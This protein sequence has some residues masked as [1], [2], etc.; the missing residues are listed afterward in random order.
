[1]GWLLGWLVGCGATPSSHPC[2][3]IPGERHTILALL[4]T[5]DDDSSTDRS[6]RLHLFLR[7]LQSRSREHS[8]FFFRPSEKWKHQRS[9]TRFIAAVAAVAAAA[10]SPLA[11]KKES[12]RSPLPYSLDRGRSVS[13]SDLAPRRRENFSKWIS[14][15]LKSQ[16][17]RSPP[18]PSF[19]LPSLS[20]HESTRA[21]H[22]A[23]H[24]V[25]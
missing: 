14:R 10:R 2:C 13:P 19:L 22:L 18:P 7:V 17:S 3:T 16:F 20:L 21:R 15:H 5:I 11:P 1:M 6:V 12:K 24:G 4:H 25:S 8:L 9:L 23:H